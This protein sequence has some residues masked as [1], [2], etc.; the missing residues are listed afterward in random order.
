[1]ASPQVVTRRKHERR[2]IEVQ[3]AKQGV[4]FDDQPLLMR[5]IGIDAQ[6]AD[7]GNSG[8]HEPSFANTAL[9]ILYSGELN[10][11]ARGPK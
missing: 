11:L 1:M 5:S 4:T 2:Q 7:P 10:G 9:Q 6:T 3:Y 8:A